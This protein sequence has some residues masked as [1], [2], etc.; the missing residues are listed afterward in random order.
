MQNKERKKIKV[1]GGINYWV[2]I[3]PCGALK[4]QG[5]LKIRG[6][7]FPA[8]VWEWDLPC[9]RLLESGL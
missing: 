9:Y 2:K 1:F 4:S 8:S 3:R 7:S 5:V 6:V